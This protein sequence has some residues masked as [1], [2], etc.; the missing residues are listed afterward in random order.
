[1]SKVSAE[2][3]EVKI[4]SGMIGIVQHTRQLAQPQQWVFN[5]KKYFYSNGLSLFYQ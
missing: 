3:N 5:D 4:D 2:L 1:M